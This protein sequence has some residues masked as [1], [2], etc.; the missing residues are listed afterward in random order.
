MT[1]GQIRNA[2][3]LYIGA[4]AVAAG[5]LL[6]LVRA[7]PSLWAAFWGR[8]AVLARGR[9]RQPAHG[10]RSADRA[11]A[12]GALALLLAIP[13][14]PGLGLGF[15]RRCWCCSSDSSS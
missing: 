14:A 1:P 13:L 2:Y 15:P 9:R 6:S 4:G 5:G 7:L 3:L 12:G 10:A 11:G 8:R